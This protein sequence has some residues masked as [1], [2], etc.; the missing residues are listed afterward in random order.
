[1]SQDSTKLKKKYR[2]EIE[3]LMTLPYVKNVRQLES[4][5]QQWPY[6]IET[7]LSSISLD[8]EIPE[9]KSC[10]FNPDSIGRGVGHTQVIYGDFS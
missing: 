5:Y 7:S 10:G 1:M 2:H 8:N 3:A 9:V 6:A 4:E